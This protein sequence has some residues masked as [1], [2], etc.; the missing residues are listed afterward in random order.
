[1]EGYLWEYSPLARA[2]DFFWKNAVDPVLRR[3]AVDDLTLLRRARGLIQ[4]LVGFSVLLIIVSPFHYTSHLLI[5]SGLLFD[6]A[7]A[8]RVFLLEEIE[9]SLAGFKPNEYGNVPSVAMREL[10]MPEDGYYDVASDDIGGF[11]YKK[12]GVLFLFAGFILQLI[13]DLV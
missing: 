11:Y 2:G 12:R 7:G 9:T 1:M 13:G 3:F 8:M 5:A 6:I 4:L 10:I